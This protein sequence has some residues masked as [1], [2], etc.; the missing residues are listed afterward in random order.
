MGGRAGG[1]G[2][3]DAENI[4]SPPSPCAARHPPTPNQVGLDS[5]RPW[6]VHRLGVDGLRPRTRGTSKRQREWGRTTAIPTCI[7]DAKVTAC[8]R[9]PLRTDLHERW[10]RDSG[11]ATPYA[12]G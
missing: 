12:N 2:G 11:L 10:P 8:A 4:K 3:A 5:S 9:P 7:T 1:E 6:H